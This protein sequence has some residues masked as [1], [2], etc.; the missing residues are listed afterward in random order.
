MT[1]MTT[2]TGPPARPIAVGVVGIGF[3]QQVHTPAFRADSRCRVV[4]VGATSLQRARSVADK[5]GVPKA[6]GDW[7]SVVADP[8]IEVI[9]VALSPSV[10]P[11]V[12]IAAAEAGKHVFCEKPAAMNATQARQMLE[13]V[14]RAGVAHAI[15]LIFP[16][17]T[18]W[19]EAKATIESGML[20]ELRHVALAWRVEQ[21][22]YRL[23][24][25]DSW[26]TK[27]EEGGGAL[28]NFVSHS[29]YYLEWL[30]G[31]I[32]KLACRLVMRLGGD[33]QVDLWLRTA[34]GVAVTA[35]VVADAF[36]GSGHR[37]DVHGD[38]GALVLENRTA[39]YVK[40]FTLAVGTRKTNTLVPVAP[41][42]A[43]SEGDGRVLAVAPI[44]R[45]LL[46]VVDARR[47]GTAEAA[48]VPNLR[49]GLRVQILLDLARASADAEGAW[50]EVPANQ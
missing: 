11:A 19:R 17:I 36:L 47:V 4:A 3:G 37:L 23:R 1:A 2:T 12:V 24:C 30:L 16:E 33:A 31:P 28:N 49:H 9:S 38:D 15:D 14:E 32:E 26:K 35:S 5:L 10:Q 50:K 29:F 42:P 48:V 45:R 44:A 41:T 18:E 20:G 34:A 8:E 6:F 46:D 39:D 43:P 21:Y 27:A 13:A 22:A 25:T 40:G 7:R